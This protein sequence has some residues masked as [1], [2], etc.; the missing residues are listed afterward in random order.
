MDGVLDS[1][2]SKQKEQEEK[3]GNWLYEGTAMNDGR[4]A[5]PPASSIR[6]LGHIIGAGLIDTTAAA[7]K[8]GWGDMI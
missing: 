6:H 7:L 1:K 8:G 5:L 4:S 3:R 2:C